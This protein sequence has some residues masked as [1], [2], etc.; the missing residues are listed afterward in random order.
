[1]RLSATETVWKPETTEPLLKERLRLSPGAIEALCSSAG[2]RQ[3]QLPSG[4]M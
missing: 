3:L 1:M 2:C 4:R